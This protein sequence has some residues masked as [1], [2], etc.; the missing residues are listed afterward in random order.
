MQNKLQTAY[1]FRTAR[2]SSLAAAGLLALAACSGT[3]AVPAQDAATQIGSW[4]P[5]VEV[6]V[7]S[8]SAEAG[9]S[10]AEALVNGEPLRFRFEQ[11][12]EGWR[13]AGMLFDGHALDHAA[14]QARWLAIVGTPR[15]L[16]FAQMEAEGRPQAPLEIVV[17]G[18]RVA[19]L[20]EETME[21]SPT[22]AGASGMVLVRGRHFDNLPIKVGD[23]VEIQVQALAREG[24]HWVPERREIPN[25]LL[26]KLEPMD[27][28]LLQL[29]KLRLSDR[30]IPIPY[31]IPDMAHEHSGGHQ[32]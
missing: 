10:V 14:A 9:G 11:Q 29:L 24:D 7:L 21:L 15:R 19:A 3:A 18:L 6:E 1:P 32:H 25:D 4:L 12:D 20:A 17:T 23:E 31:N 2:R 27:V 26:L 5:A 22:A 13:L 16:S 28:T 30:V 8:T